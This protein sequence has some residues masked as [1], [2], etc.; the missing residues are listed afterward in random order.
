MPGFTLCVDNFLRLC[1]RV[2]QGFSNVFAYVPLSMK[3]II[4]QHL[5]YAGGIKLYEY[6]D[7]FQFSLDQITLEP[8]PNIFRLWRQSWSQ[9]NSDS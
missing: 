9:K 4:S 1:V 8:E 7:G 6:F 5:I 3:Y 2:D